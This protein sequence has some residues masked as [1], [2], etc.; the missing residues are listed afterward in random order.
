[1]QLDIQ[2]HVKSRRYKLLAYLRLVPHDHIHSIIEIRKSRLIRRHLNK[3]VIRMQSSSIRFCPSLWPDMSLLFLN[4]PKEQGR[5][6]RTDREQTRT[7][8][9]EGKKERGR[10]GERERCTG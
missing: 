7:S 2:N 4:E 6:R 5:E 10:A 3:P 8:R 9:V 1:M